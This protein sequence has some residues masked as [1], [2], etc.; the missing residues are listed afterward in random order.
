MSEEKELIDRLINL[1]K[2]TGKHGQYQSISS[3]LEPFLGGYCSAT[4][5]RFEK[6]RM[7]FILKFI[8]P[9]G[10]S[11][12]DIGGNVG[13]FSFEMIACGAKSVTY[14]ESNE[15]CAEFVKTAVKLLGLESR[16]DIRERGFPFEKT[17]RELYTLTLLL[18]VLHHIGDDFDQKVGDPSEAKSLI[19]HYLNGLSKITKFLVFQM[20]FCW[21]GNVN[22][23]LFPKGT[24][25]EMIRYLVE[26][27][28]DFWTIETIGVPEKRGIDIVYSPLNSKNILR[29]DN[30]GE[31]LN[32]PLFILRSK[33]IVTVLN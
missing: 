11:V 12:L 8:D 20:G 33:R 6:E 10:E 1:Y 9:T 5:P 19:L 29:D 23:L 3:L 24:K 21:K 30:L 7:Q 18:N 16:I 31:F 13:F 2:V 14:Y 28:S 15:A 25:E 17:P 22:F 32:R 26:G 4:K 27:V